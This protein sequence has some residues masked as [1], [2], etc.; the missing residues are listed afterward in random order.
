MADYEIKTGGNVDLVFLG[1]EKLIIKSDYFEKDLCYLEGLDDFR[2]EFVDS[3][4]HLEQKRSILKL[5]INEM[6][7]AQ[8]S[9]SLAHVMARFS[10]FVERVKN[11]YR[12]YISEFSFEKI[13]A[14]VEK[15]K[16]E[17]TSRLNKVFSDIQNQILAIPVALIL[18]GG[19]MERTGVLEISNLLIWFGALIFGVLTW[20]L[21]KNQKSTLNAVKNEYAEQKRKIK[22]QNKDIADKFECIYKTLEERFKGI[23]F[24]LIFVQCLI[25]ASFVGTTALF[26]WYSMPCSMAYYLRFIFNKL[27]LVGY[28]L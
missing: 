18:A 1:K 14:E 25:V 19:Q 2:K 22:D 15:Q 23:K 10:E 7:F 4:I 5:I 21:I 24:M 3:P 16:T 6:F 17:F 28:M 13:R 12:L 27:N 9:I 11:S 26:C 8:K 20:M